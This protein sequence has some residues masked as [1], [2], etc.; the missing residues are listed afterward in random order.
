MRIL[1]LGS[2]GM[3]GSDCKA[4]LSAD[5]QVMAPER[6]E[7]DIRSWDGVV[8]NL[9]K[10]HPEVILNCVAFSDVDAAEGNERLVRKIN[11]EGPRNLAQASA[12]YQAKL[13]HISSDYIFDGQKTA[14]QPYFEDDA[15]SPLSVYGKSKM[16]SEVAV[17]DNSPNYIIVRTGWLY[18]TQGRSFVKSI[19]Q[20]AVR[21]K[22]EI[23][24]VVDDQ[25]GSPTW[26][27]RLAQQIKILMEKEGRGTYHAT[28]EGYCS[29]L[30]CA[31]HILRRMELKNRI[32]AVKISDFPS[33]A[34]RPAN[35]VLENRRLKKQ[36]LNIM[37]PWEEDLDAF[38]EAHAEALVREAQ[39]QKGEEPSKSKGITRR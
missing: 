33:V 3:L 9:L 38:L 31:R 19:L 13:I 14:P 39:E 36:G 34:R 10:S 25:F 37:V 5:H 15:P 2:T 30:D 28:A 18:G 20:K 12:R 17:R 35:C 21:S 6:K 16:E 24:R 32:E 8:E 1:L 7:L 23:L 22:K 4:V 26:T 29:R 11:V 27:Q